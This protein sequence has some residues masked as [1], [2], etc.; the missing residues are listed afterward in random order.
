MHAITTGDARA[1]TA[2]GKLN[3]WIADETGGNPGGIRPG[4]A[5]DGN[6]TGGD[7]TDMCFVAPFGVAAMVG[8]SHQ[9][10]LNSVWDFVV[11]EGAEGYYQDTV[12]LLSMMAMSGN[13]WTP[14]S[15]SCP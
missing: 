4:Y 1:R 6:V 5:L 10:W 2:V 15:I 13:W 3:D 9:A 14:E 12:K 11:D 7:Y 8:S